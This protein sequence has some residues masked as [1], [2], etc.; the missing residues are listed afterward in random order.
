MYFHV[1]HMPEANSIRKQYSL[2]EKNLH[3]TL[4]AKDDHHIEKGI[5]SIV[6]QRQLTIQEI[7]HIMDN[8]GT[9]EETNIQTKSFIYSNHPSEKVF[10]NIIACY[11][12]DM[13][14]AIDFAEI[15]S[16]EHPTWC[17]PYICI[18]DLFYKNNN[19]K[20]AM[21]SYLAAWHKTNKEK[22]KIYIILRTNKLL[23]SY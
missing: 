7:T 13:E 6:Y 18:G 10:S 3:I 1:I 5:S 21:L 15:A 4:T 22:E 12:N 17:A 2:P 14:F 8:R 20:L 9:D 16:R 23:Q 11:R 19:Y